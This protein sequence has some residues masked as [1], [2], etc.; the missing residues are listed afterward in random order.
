MGH[1]KKNTQDRFTA[2]EREAFIASGLVTHDKLEK[3]SDKL[4]QFHE[5]IVPL[6]RTIRNPVEKAK[7]LF[8]WLWAEKPARYKFHASFK[9]HQVIDAQINE[10]SETVGNCLG[11]TLLYNCLLRRLGI[12]SE[13]LHLENAF[14]I[15]PHVMTILQSEKVLIDIDNILPDGFDYR[16]HLHNPS[17]TRWGDKEL[18][19]D[20]YHSMGNEEFEKGNYEKALKG[21][22]EAIRLNP[23]YEKAHLNRVI[24][25]DR[26]NMGKRR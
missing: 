1:D 16:G 4:A 21:Y 11:L 5:K 15:G 26:Q 9:L 10:T 18:V 3:Y 23:A 13:A 14:G 12:Y 25:L 2:L 20:I 17:R 24:L 8:E 22:N 6:L 7:R 19:A